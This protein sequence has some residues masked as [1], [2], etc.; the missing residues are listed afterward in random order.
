M[1]AMP[2]DSQC[3][4]TARASAAPFWKLYDDLASGVDPTVR[5]DEFS[6]GVAWFGV[7]AGGALGLAMSPP[8][9][10]DTPTQA[11]RIAGSPLHEVASGIKSWNWADAALGAAAINAHYNQPERVKEH[12]RI[13]GGML[14]DLNAFEYYRPS[15]RGA[16]VAVVGHFRN[17]ERVADVCDLT[18]LER[19]PGAGDTPDTACET[20][21]PQADWV[22]ITATTLINKT[23]PRLLELSRGAQVVLVGPTAPLTFD[24]SSHGI[25]AVAGLCIDD[26]RSVWRVI[27]EGGRHEFFSQGTR[28]ALFERP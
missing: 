11:G 28:Y 19:R 5:V 15:Y 9:G 25:R 18:I 12:A 24:W 26:T 13:H 21:L 16:K 1:F 8:E 6:A 7:R 4:R 27:Q 22:F 23:L 14:H 17:L 3:S 2:S 20:V 10:R